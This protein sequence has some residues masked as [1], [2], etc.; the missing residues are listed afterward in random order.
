MCKVLT[1]KKVFKFVKGKRDDKNKESGGI[2][3][4]QSG[5]LTSPAQTPEDERFLGLDTSS[6]YIVDFC[7]KDKTLTKLHKAAWQGSL[8]KLKSALKKIEIDAVDRHNRSALHF[9]V[10]QGHPNIVWFLLG[11]NAKMTICDDEGKTPLLKA[12]ECGHKECMTLLLERGADINNTDYS[13]NTGLHIA[14]KQGSLDIASA[15]LQRGADFEISNNCGEYPLHIATRAQN[16]DLVEL[17]LRCGASVN[18]FDREN[19]TPLMLAAKHGNLLLAQLF[20]EYG[21]QLTVVDSNGWT[22]EDYALLGG[23]Q[24]VASELKTLIKNE[25]A[26]D[27]FTLETHNEED[28]E[29]IKSNENSG[30]WNDSQ[31]SEEPKDPIS[32]KLQ[33]FFKKCSNEEVDAQDND[34]LEDSPG[35]GVVPPPCQPPR[36][37][38]IIQAGMIDDTKDGEEPKRRSITTLGTLHSRRESFTEALANNTQNEVPRYTLS[39]NR[40]KDVKRNNSFAK[41]RLSFNEEESLKS[42]INDDGSIKDVEKIDLD[43]ILNFASIKPKK[44][45]SS[46]ESDWDS[47][48]N[49]ELDDIKER[50][51]KSKQIGSLQKK[52][53]FLLRESPIDLT[54]SDSDK[55][56]S[57]KDGGALGT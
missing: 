1:M 41:Q 13:G 10:V 33:Q 36:S 45:N 34:N 35:S 30:T 28:E 8:D 9:A 21:A 53:K 14:A 32:Q 50:I 39:L 12:I 54:P 29:N 18:V 56:E 46:S 51:Q 57:H 38:D 31:I 26:K 2:T 27:G 48:N 3:P 20:F 43:S 17:L 11:N 52:D 44:R 23:H 40:R 5:D 49:S 6:G 4:S 19:R 47:T 7:G 15:L 24:N 37:W 16:K 42:W 25:G 22:A 55:T